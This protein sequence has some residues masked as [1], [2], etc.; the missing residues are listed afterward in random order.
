MNQ[1]SSIGFGPNAE[2]LSAYAHTV[3]RRLGNI[4][5]V[6]EN[7]GDNTLWIQVRQFD[8]VASPSG[9]ANVGAALLI[10]P[11]GTVTASYNLLGKEIGFFGSGNTSI[12]GTG[13]ATSAKANISTIIRNKSDLRGAQ[14]DIE[15]V[16]RK[17]WGYDAAFNRGNLTKEWGSV[18][19]DSGDITPGEGV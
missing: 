19:P 8:G 11:G 3:N 15:P 4:D 10:V 16:G 1:I 13:T 2:L 9:Y 14:I 12:D 6:F 18:D 5:F 7:T 17:G